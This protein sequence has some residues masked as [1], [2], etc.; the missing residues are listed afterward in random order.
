[1]RHLVFIIIYAAVLTG[2]VSHKPDPHLVGHYEAPTGEAIDIQLDGK[3]VYFFHDKVDFIG[4]LNVENRNPIVVHVIAP[5]AAPLVGTKILFSAD[6][7]EIQVQWPTS[8]QASNSS[9]RPTRY[10]AK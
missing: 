3:I 5:G 2:C 8:T 1:M 9:Q 6:K 4:L 7:T 10:Y